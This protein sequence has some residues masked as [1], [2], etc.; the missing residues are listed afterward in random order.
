MSATRFVLL[1]G[2]WSAPGCVNFADEADRSDSGAETDAGLSP[3][4]GAT[5]AG[6]TDAGATD[7]GVTDAG[8]TDAGATDAGGTDAG[9]TDAGGTDAGCP[10]GMIRLDGGTFAMGTRLLVDGGP[11][12]V[13]V[14]SFCLDETEVTVAAFSLPDGGLAPTS[15]VECNGIRGDRQDHPANCIDWHEADAHCRYVGK[16][17]PTEEEWEW[18]ARGGPAARSFPWGN[19]APM[20]EACWRGASIPATSTCP[21]GSNPGG[22]TPQGLKDLAGNVWEWTSSCSVC[23]NRIYRGGGWYDTT[24]GNLSVSLR[25]QDPPG[26]R[27]YNIGVRCAQAL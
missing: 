24:G 19:T 1:V 8:A 4:A 10:P 17:L 5:D 14:S 11:D 20:N 13:T 22:T 26:T 16:R 15:P 23:P 3:D 7:A 6:A 18:A 2:L 25:Y 21:V 27:N 9:G 12:V